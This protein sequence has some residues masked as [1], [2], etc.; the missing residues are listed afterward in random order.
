MVDKISALPGAVEK[1]SA[2]IRNQYLL[3]YV[4]DNPANDGLYR[5]VEVRLNQQSDTP[6]LRASWRTGYYAPAGE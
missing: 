5:K 2:A 6:R 4:S 1:I 3:G